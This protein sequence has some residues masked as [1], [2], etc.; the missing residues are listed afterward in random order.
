MQD[1]LEMEEGGVVK[2]KRTISLSLGV[3]I[4]IKKRRIAG[5]ALRD[6][7]NNQSKGKLEIT[8]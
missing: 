1:G 3:K 6:E 2:G 5:R 8:R 4:P 7:T